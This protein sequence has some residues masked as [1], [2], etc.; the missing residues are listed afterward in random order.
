MQRSLVFI[1]LLIASIIA[2]AFWAWT[3]LESKRRNHDHVE[4]FETEEVN[5]Q[6]DAMLNAYTPP[7]ADANALRP[8]TVYFTERMTACDSGMMKYNRKVYERKLADLKDQIAVTTGQPTP[9]DLNKISLLNKMMD[10]YDALPYPKTCKLTLP[11]WYQLSQNDGT[12]PPLGDLA[13]NKDR[14]TSDQWGICYR[15]DATI[16]SVERTGM[17]L[18]RE[19]NNVPKSLVIGGKPYMRGRF[20]D[21]KVDT[22]KRAYCEETK[23]SVQP[24]VFQTGFLIEKGSSAQ[25]DYKIYSEGRQVAITQDI[26]DKYF[27]NIMYT[28]V[29][30]KVIIDRVQYEENNMEPQV[31]FMTIRKCMRDVCGRWVVEYSGR[32]SVMFKLPILQKRIQL[33]IG[34]DYLLGTMQDLMDRYSA[35]VVLSNKY[36]KLYNEAKANEDDT[37]A[38]L[39][40]ERTNKDTA[41]TNLTNATNA[42]DNAK[43]AKDIAWSSKESWQNTYNGLNNELSGINR[44]NLCD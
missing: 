2:V 36:K 17:V 5:D 14:A 44:D 38:K 15:A 18:E 27:T 12:T 16:A 25:P 29:V 24:Y 10:A 13:R 4:P 28:E 9:E 39:K 32:T 23:T 3:H 31:R 30:R 22:V 43:S 21:F 42:R 11:N 37:S 8:C 26:V 7:A 34:K 20:A 33:G 35:S 1:I 40:T 6:N 41:Q 19:A